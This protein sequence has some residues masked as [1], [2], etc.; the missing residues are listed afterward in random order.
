MKEIIHDSDYMDMELGFAYR[1]LN[2]H[3]LMASAHQHNYYEYFL[4]T[5]GR[6]IH[7]VNKK[8]ETLS[9][10]DLVF[11]RPNDYHSYELRES[12]SFTMINVSF[13]VPHFLAACQYLGGDIEHLLTEPSQPPTINILPFANCSLEENHNILNFFVGTNTDLSMHF[14]FLLSETLLT[15]SRYFRLEQEASYDV[16]LHSVLGQM[17]SQE[18]IEEGIPALLRI[19]GVS[20]GHLCRLMKQQLHMT[21]QQYITKLRMNYA[22]R[23]LSNSSY[24]VL[25]ISLKCGYSSLSHFITTFK[26]IH[27]VVPHNYR[28]LYSNFDNWK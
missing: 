5:S 12:D 27:G 10:G 6:L 25:D 17:S 13:R 16:W 14:R 1:F 23:L 19:S 11:I 9:R 20:H 2:Q 22:A 8:K 4:V 18:N 24:S 21:P 15:F 26:K 3:S 7:K 28:Q